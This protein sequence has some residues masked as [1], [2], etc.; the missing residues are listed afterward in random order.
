MITSAVREAV[1][2]VDQ[3][4]PV[5]DLRTLRPARRPEV[6]ALLTRLS[7]DAEAEIAKA[8]GDSLLALPFHGNLSEDDI[9]Y[10]CEAIAA[11]P[12]MVRAKSL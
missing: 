12:R 8:A 9:D 11:A 7:S 4:Q 5:Y 10:V 3:D 1:R 2:A 6:V